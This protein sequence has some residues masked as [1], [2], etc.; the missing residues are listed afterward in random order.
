MSSFVLKIRLLSTTVLIAL[1]NIHELSLIS[2]RFV[3]LLYLYLVSLAKLARP[4]FIH[5]HVKNVWN[6]QL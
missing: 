2:N 1:A 5:N 4:V 6:I 3:A